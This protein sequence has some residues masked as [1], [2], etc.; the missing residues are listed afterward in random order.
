MGL[1]HDGDVVPPFEEVHD[2]GE[3]GIGRRLH[4]RTVGAKHQ[5]DLG[6]NGKVERRMHIDALGVLK[7]V[8]GGGAGDHLT[9]RGRT[10]PCIDLGTHRGPYRVGRASHHAATVGQPR[11]QN[12]WGAVVNGEHRDVK[13]VGPGHEVVFG[14]AL[15]RAH[16]HHHVR[17]P[18]QP[19][20]ERWA[21][22]SVRAFHRTHTFA[23]FVVPC[24]A[25]VPVAVWRP[26]GTT[27]QHATEVAPE[28]RRGFNV[29]LTW[30]G[31][32]NDESSLVPCV[33][34]RLH[35]GV[36][37]LSVV[38]HLPGVQERTHAKRRALPLLGTRALGSARARRTCRRLAEVNECVGCLLLFGTSTRREVGQNAPLLR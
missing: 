15:V 22:K 14:V 26:P 23:V 38:G 32:R 16:H 5:D 1:V 29:P 30:G 24:C 2:C 27:P 9:F 13:R 35:D 31:R 28:P 11:P 25:F 18:W 17:A 12:G 33:S 19:R 36:H 20:P 4:G 8:D 3:G 6:A 34:E 37:M 7:A 21:G 10:R